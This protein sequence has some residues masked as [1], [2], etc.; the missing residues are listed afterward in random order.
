[1]ILQY[2]QHL[3]FTA[4]TIPIGSFSR[5]LSALGDKMKSSSINKRLDLKFII[6]DE[7]SMVS[8]DL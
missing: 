3:I 7:I 4:L 5:N 2:I 6:V 8:N 1:M